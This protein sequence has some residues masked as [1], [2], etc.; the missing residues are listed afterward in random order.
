MSAPQGEHGLHEG[1]EGVNVVTLERPEQERARI[2]RV[3]ETWETGLW[4]HIESLGWLY[5]SGFLLWLLW[6]ELQNHGVGN[7]KVVSSY[8]YAVIILFLSSDL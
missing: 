6:L 3:V 5:Y 1:S 7:K 4:E 2:F 8:G